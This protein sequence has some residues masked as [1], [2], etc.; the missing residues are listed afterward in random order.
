[1]QVFDGDYNINTLECNI[2]KF[3]HWFEWGKKILHLF[4][5]VNIS[6]KIL[7]LKIDF[8]IPLFS[9]SVISKEGEI[10]LLGGELDKMASN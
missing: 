8:N 9:W 7:E 5:V 3:L 10:Y 2:P 1:V 4:D 6:H